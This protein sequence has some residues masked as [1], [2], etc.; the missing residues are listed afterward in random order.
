MQNVITETPQKK[1]M[2]LPP[3][4]EDKHSKLVFFMDKMG[5]IT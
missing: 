5:T 4:G 1:Q 2:T 3:S